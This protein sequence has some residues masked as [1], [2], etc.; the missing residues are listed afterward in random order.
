MATTAQEIQELN[1]LMSNFIQ[2]QSRI[3]EEQRKLAESTRHV[4]EQLDIY[5]DS[6]GDTTKLSKNQ[7]ELYR[8]AMTEKRRELELAQK[9]QIQNKKL[10][11]IQS[12]IAAAGVATQQQLEQKQHTES[13][14][15]AYQNQ[16]SGA[17]TN[18]NKAQ[19]KFTHSTSG[20]TGIFNKLAGTSSGLGFGFAG[21]IGKLGIL[22]LVLDQLSKAIDQAGKVMAAN[23][24]VIEGRSI[25]EGIRQQFMAAMSRGVSLEEIGKINAE[26]RQASNAVG[27]FQ[28][29]LALTKPLFNDYF[30]A[31]GNTTEAN[32]QAYQ[33]IQA[34]TRLG[35]RP[36]TDML[37]QYSSDLETQRMINGMSLEQSRQMFDSVA[38]EI[39]SLSILKAVRKGERQSILENQRV[40]LL[41]NQALG[42]TAQQASEAAKMLNKMVAAKPLERLKQA[43]KIQ[44]YGAAMGLGPEATAAAAELR[45]PKGQQDPRVISAFLTA[46][47][48]MQDAAAQQGLA[49]EI[50]S[51]AIMDKLGLEQLLGPESS[52]STTLAEAQAKP[53]KELQSTFVSFKDSYVS[54]AVEIKQIGENVVKLTADGSTA[55]WMLMEAAGGLKKLESSTGDSITGMIDK[56]FSSVSDFFSGSLDFI[57]NELVELGN[58]VLGSFLLPILGISTAFYS[59]LGGLTAV[60]S[61][62]SGW[63]GMESAEGAW[64]ASSERM[65]NMASGYWNKM[66]GEDETQTTIPTSKL[67]DKNKPEQSIDDIKKAQSSAAVKQSADNSSRLLDISKNHTH[68]FNE[69]LSKM[70]ESTKYLKILADNSPTLVDLAQKQL[71]A[72]TMSETQKQKYAGSLSRTSGKFAAEYATIE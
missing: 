39:D 45:K 40:L 38:S 2:S 8:K 17:I 49:A 37:S 57:G 12:Q 4:N 9:I 28:N 22:G 27:G 29:T 24:G 44:A 64:K 67:T 65:Y 66:V 19:S 62:L 58:T 36:A 10:L 72:L 11:D 41:N 13:L 69:Q 70:D 50:T 48:N 14:L 3:T 56:M 53:L 55:M 34:F 20:L 5:D 16:Y 52:F 42:M 71:A 6:L 15:A 21:I 43:A 30:A 7:T 68:T 51:T 33:T 59:T 23:A 18:S 35:I 54:S 25:E 47:T 46:A 61:K 31:T 60:F 1:R 63:F 32:K 26:V